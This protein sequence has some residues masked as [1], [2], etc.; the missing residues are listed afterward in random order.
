MY[1]FSVK[2]ITKSIALVKYCTKQKA[3]SFHMLLFY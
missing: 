1:N 2:K 3:V